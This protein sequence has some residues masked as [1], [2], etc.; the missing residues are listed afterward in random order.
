LPSNAWMV[1]ESHD[2]PSR[3]SPERQRSRMAINLH[4]YSVHIS[5]RGHPAA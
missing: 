2:A 3:T 1:T 4:R 5:D